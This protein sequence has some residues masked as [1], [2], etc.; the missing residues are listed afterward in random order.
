MELPGT[1]EWPGNSRPSES[2]EGG[3]P[4]ILF[5]S[6]TKMDRR[7]I[8]GLRWKLG[9]TNLV[10]NDCNGKSGGLAI[11]WRKE[12]DLHLRG[13]SRLYIDADVV[14][15]DGFVWRFTGFYGE[16]KS[17]KKDLSWKVL[18]TLSAARRRPWLRVGDFNE[19]LLGCEKEGG[20]PKPQGCMDRFRQALEDCELTE[21]WVMWE[22]CSR[23]GTIAIAVKT[24]LGRG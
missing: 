20:Q 15:A 17:E 13:T 21:I 7:R 9:L 10:V 12:I 11:F 23:G 16:P 19:V 14:E 8:E 22:T 5:L 3:G 24:T 18:R 6:E 4:D 2:S 1:G